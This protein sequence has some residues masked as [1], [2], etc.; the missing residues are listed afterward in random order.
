MHSCIA[1]IDLLFFGYQLSCL[2]KL[3]LLDL[4]VGFFAVGIQQKRTSA[5]GIHSKNQD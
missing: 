3:K 5:A 2:A 4:R 1:G